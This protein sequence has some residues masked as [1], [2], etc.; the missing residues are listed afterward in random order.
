MTGLRKILKILTDNG[1]MRIKGKYRIRVILIEFTRETDNEEEEY[2][3]E[4]DMREAYCWLQDTKLEEKGYC[5][6]RKILTLKKEEKEVKYKIGELI[7]S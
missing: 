5:D 4:E 3:S 7:G 6:I 1:E 2:E